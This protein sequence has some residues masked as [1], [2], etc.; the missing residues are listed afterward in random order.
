M[1][2]GNED[3]LEKDRENAENCGCLVRS[4]PRP[5]DPNSRRKA[6]THVDFAAPA[7]IPTPSDPMSITIKGSNYD[8]I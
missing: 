7:S 8:I 6:Q 2:P 5:P 1:V 4:P 3:S